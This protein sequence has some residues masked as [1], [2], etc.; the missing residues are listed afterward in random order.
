MNPG[1]SG[2]TATKPIIRH[3]QRTEDGVEL[4][5]HVPPAL[6]YFRGHFPGFAILPGIVQIDWALM[7]A[8]DFLSV[9]E[10]AAVAMRVKF[11]RPIQPGMDLQ[12]TLDYSS[13]RRLLHFEYRDETWTYGSGRIELGI[14]GF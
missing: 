12:L 9:P 1:A 6:A 11:A 4:S 7:L 14:D 5:L 10:N 13:A 2:S 8:R 3:T